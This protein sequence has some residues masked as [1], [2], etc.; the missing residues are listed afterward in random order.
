MLRIILVFVFSFVAAGCGSSD[1][2]DSEVVEV[3]LRPDFD[4]TSDC[5]DASIVEPLPSGSVPAAFVGNW[6][7]TGTFTTSL[8]LDPIPIRSTTSINSNGAFRTTIV[9]GTEYPED[10]R[11]QW[12]Q[13]RIGTAPPAIAGH[14][15]VTDTQ[16]CTRYDVAP[17]RYLCGPLSRIDAAG[18]WFSFPGTVEVYEHG[19]F[20]RSYLSEVTS[21]CVKQ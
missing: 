19:D 13:C 1:N 4:E 18:Q 21:V 9:S 11:K 14:L 5:E 16:E 3:R 10:F 17:F 7:C 15:V 8:D 20:V 12:N 6:S 2:G